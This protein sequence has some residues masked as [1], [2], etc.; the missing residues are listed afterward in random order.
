MMTEHELDKLIKV[1]TEQQTVSVTFT[2]EQI[3][4][5]RDIV[6]DKVLPIIEGYEGYPPQTTE[7]DTHDLT[8]HAYFSLCQRLGVGEWDGLD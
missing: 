1:D 4:A 6:S 7:L 3:T 5:L 8:A 2:L